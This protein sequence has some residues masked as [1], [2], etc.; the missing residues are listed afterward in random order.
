MKDYDKTACPDKEL[1]R[2]AILAQSPLRICRGLWL[3]SAECLDVSLF[4][5]NGNITDDTEVV[6]VERDPATFKLM[7]HKL[8]AMGI[9]NLDGIKGEVED[10]INKKHFDFVHVDWCGF[11]NLRRFKWISKSIAP[12]VRKDSVVVFTVMSSY[13]DE[14]IM[15]EL[16]KVCKDKFSDDRAD[17]IG[18][19]TY[20]NHLAASLKKTEPFTEQEHLYFVMPHFMLRCVFNLH[21]LCPMEIVNH[22]YQDTKPMSV[23]ILKDFDVVSFKLPNLY[24]II[25]ELPE[26]IEHLSRLRSGDPAITW[27]EVLKQRAKS[28]A[29]EQAYND[30][31]AAKK[32]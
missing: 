8:K 29:L 18:Y 11:F 17:R 7:M 19:K 3:P 26:D 1:A 5:D 23:F 15:P 24:E 32:K 10:Y 21:G 28:L 31:Q 4:K 13:R 14:V 20:D 16:V 2:Q 30:Q 27:E 6:A 22:E 12:F 9:K 25:D